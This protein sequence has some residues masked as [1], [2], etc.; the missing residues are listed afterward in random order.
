MMA[1]MATPDLTT[2]PILTTIWR[3]SLPN[4][5]AMVATA[6]VSVA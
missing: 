4:M 2:A 5:F 1:A 6:L 3:L